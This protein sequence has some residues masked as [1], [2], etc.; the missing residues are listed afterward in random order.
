MNVYVPKV[1]LPANAYERS[2]S[3]ISVRN[4]DAL[5]PGDIILS[6]GKKNKISWLIRVATASEYSHVVLHVGHGIAVE[7][8][9]PGVVPVFLPAVG[10]DVNT[11]VHVRRVEG[12]TPQQQNSLVDFVWD[13]LYRPYSTRGALS[14]VRLLSRLRPQSDPGYFCS[15]LVAAAYKIEN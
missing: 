7:A 5:L 8:N 1:K 3:E 10:Y 11:R 15:R 4:A 6:T 13:V 12:L 9:D 14:S 2:M